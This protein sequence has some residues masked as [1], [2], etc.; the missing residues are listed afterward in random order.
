MC[1][2]YSFK[3]SPEES[4]ALFDYR[5]EPSF[6]AR[7]HVAPEEPIA[8]VRADRRERRFA[9]VRWG[10]VPSWVKEAKPGRPLINARAETVT[11]RAS[12]RYAMMR[13]RC[14]IPA[15]GFYEWMG[16]SGRKQAFLFRR[17]DD[18]LFAFAGLWEYWSGND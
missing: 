5:D 14:L 2:L 18:R 6:P 16:E 4:R 11:T 17:P 10:L 1:G 9:L 13:R 15:D 12:F 7:S 3:S 8:I